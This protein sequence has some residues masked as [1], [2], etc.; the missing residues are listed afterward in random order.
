MRPEDL[1]RIVCGDFEKLNTADEMD[2]YAGVVLTKNFIDNRNIDIAYLSR[3]SKI[4]IECLNRSQER[5]YRSGAFL[6]YSWINMNI[7]VL[8][9]D[10]S[11]NKS[12]TLD[13]CYIAGKASGFI[14]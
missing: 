6:P 12:S 9:K 14:L 11:R 13:W 8:R 10:I 5:L 2:G 3:V 1:A 7:N 4:P